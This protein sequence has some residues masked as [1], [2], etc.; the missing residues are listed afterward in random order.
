MKLFYTFTCGERLH[1]SI[2]KEEMNRKA[3]LPT[4][5]I[6]SAI[7]EFR[8]RHLSELT[9]LCEASGSS[10]G[11][12]Y[13]RVMTKPKSQPLDPSDD[14]ITQLLTEHWQYEYASVSEED[15]RKNCIG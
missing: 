11:Y 13:S 12:G 6:A 2:E 10:L 15:N 9:E 3:K 1:L 5:E 14:M 7:N 8:S 4:S